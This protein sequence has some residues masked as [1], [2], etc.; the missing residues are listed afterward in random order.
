MSQKPD[1]YDFLAR[2][3]QER[4]VIFYGDNCTLSIQLHL[5]VTGLMLLK[6]TCSFHGNK[7]R[8]VAV[9]ADFEHAIVDKAIDQWRKRLQA[10]VKAK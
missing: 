8:L 6:T 10:C 9:W 7:E 2:L 5:Q 4:T 3:H 1:L